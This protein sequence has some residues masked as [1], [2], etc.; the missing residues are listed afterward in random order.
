LTGAVIVIMSF[1]GLLLAYEHQISNL[2][3]H[4]Y[5]S[6]APRAGEARLGPGNLMVKVC[7][8]Q[9]SPASTVT[10][11]SDPGLP[12]EIGLGSD[13]TAYFNAY[14]GEPTGAGLQKL[15][16]FFATV[17]GWHRWLGAPPNYRSAARTLTG[18]CN[19]VFLLLVCTGMFLW[20]PKSW[21]WP[22]FKT[23]IT[24][25]WDQ[26]PGRARD[27]NWHT[28][29]GF[30]CTLPLLVIVPCGVV[31]SFPWANNL[32]YR[33][34]GNSPPPPLQ[35]SSASVSP[36]TAGRS[37]SGM[38]RRGTDRG[39]FGTAFV[40]DGRS[41]NNG[42]SRWDVA[43]LNH[44]WDRAEEQ[45]SGWQS[46]SLGLPAPDATAVVFSIDRG[47]GG[48]PNQRSQLTLNWQS[49]NVVRW[50]PFSSYN[51]GRRLRMWVRF[52]H[53][54]EAGGLLGQ[55]IAAL[56]S[57][58]AIIIVISGM[59]MAWKRIFA[60]WIRSVRRRTKLVATGHE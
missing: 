48:L 32:L 3:A 20:W 22:R 10:I 49:G 34:T 30:W 7:A 18:I 46:I 17:R 9:S 13:R 21:S 25:R 24:W 37:P 57:V 54:G 59:A 19:L 4:V 5:R 43:S 8:T 12:V 27:W 52:S 16:S 31:M 40:E 28:V 38:N 6:A 39:E 41:G 45:V 56:A 44:L 33:L 50:E 47:N 29:T 36:F 1:T 11:H 14:T 51:S 35:A 55:T 58:G 60:G 42:C 23:A 2:L 26:P 53:T 15:R